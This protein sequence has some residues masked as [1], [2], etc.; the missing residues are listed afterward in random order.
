MFR[1]LMKTL[2]FT[3]LIRTICQTFKKI[4]GLELDK[5]DR[6]NRTIFRRKTV[7]D[8]F[9]YLCDTEKLSQ[10]KITVFISDV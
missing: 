8:L 6:T 1:C 2:V 9:H 4:S 5:Q 7:L 3:N 10:Q